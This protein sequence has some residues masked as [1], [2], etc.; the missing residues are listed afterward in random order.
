ML[1]NLETLFPL[2]A[3]LG[4]T[5]IVLHCNEC[6]GTKGKLLGR[7]PGLHWEVVGGYSFLSWVLTPPWGR[8]AEASSPLRPLKSCV[9]FPPAQ[10]WAQCGGHRAP[11]S[12]GHPK[13]GSACPTPPSPG[14]GSLSCLGAGKL[15]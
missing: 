14:Q 3:P 8:R 11:L 1:I 5:A 2:G 9:S 15:C 4:C 12:G 6:A 7:H 13:P 10:A